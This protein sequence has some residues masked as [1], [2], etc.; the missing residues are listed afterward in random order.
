MAVNSGLESRRNYGSYDSG[1]NAETFEQAKDIIKTRLRF[2]RMDLGIHTKIEDT[3]IAELLMA[4][5]DKRQSLMDLYAH[6]YSPCK[7]SEPEYVVKGNGDMNDVMIDFS[8]GYD[9]FI[10]SM[11]DEYVNQ[12]MRRRSATIL[13]SRM[14]SIEY[15]CSKIM[16][17]YYYKSLSAE[18]IAE[19]MFISR[20]TFYR[21][22]NAGL[23]ILTGIYYP[24][25]ANDENETEQAVKEE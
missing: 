1:D 2:L 13:L 6:L 10:Q 9:K 23:T 19:E 21:I 5:E 17:L 3:L 15:P 25:L 11:S 22:K 14:L 24:Q 8:D 18:E 7:V 12:L 16:Y 4:Y 20:A